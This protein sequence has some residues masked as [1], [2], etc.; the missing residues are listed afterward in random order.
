MS[1]RSGREKFKLMEI[2]LICTVLLLL[3][4]SWDNTRYLKILVLVC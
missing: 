1:I 4:R 2:L 3:S